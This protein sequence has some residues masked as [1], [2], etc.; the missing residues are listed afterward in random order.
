[1]RRTGANHE[2][3]PGAHGGLEAFGTMTLS[4]GSLMFEKPKLSS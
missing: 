3:Q 4:S 1:M 2:N